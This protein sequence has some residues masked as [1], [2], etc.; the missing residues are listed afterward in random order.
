MMM[1]MM[2]DEDLTVTADERWK[3]EGRK[4]VA[5]TLMGMEVG[6]EEAWPVERMNTVRVSCTLYGLRWRRRFATR[7]NREERTVVVKR[8]E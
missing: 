1:T 4:P 2:K 3:R 7:V 6:M 8:V 5:E